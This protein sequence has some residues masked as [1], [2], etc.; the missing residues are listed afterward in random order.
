M[1]VYR[2]ALADLIPDRLTGSLFRLT[3]DVPA[4]K[5]R[6][7]SVLYVDYSSRGQRPTL[8]PAAFGRPSARPIPRS[9]FSALALEADAFELVT[10]RW[11]EEEARR[12]LRRT[13]AS[14]AGSH[15]CGNAQHIN[16]SQ[17]WIVQ[18]GV[19]RRESVTAPLRASSDDVAIGMLILDSGCRPPRG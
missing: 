8:I 16:T 18:V 15:R 14:A 11:P 2:D 19:M 17:L 4:V 10:A 3:R 13:L 7:W 6:R 9:M 5:L 12:K 1:H